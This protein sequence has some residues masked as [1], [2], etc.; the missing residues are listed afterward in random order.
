MRMNDDKRATRWW[1]AMVLLLA[2]GAAEAVP[3]SYSFTLG[4]AGSGGFTVRADADAPIIQYNA[5]R[6]ELSAFNWDIPGV[7][8]FDLADLGV[9]SLSSWNPA[10]GLVASGG[11]LSLL[12][13]LKAGASSDTGVG[14]LT[15]TLFSVVSWPPSGQ[16]SN[17]L[18]L[19]MINAQGSPCTSPG[20]LCAPLVP[21][22][23][24]AE[25]APTARLL[26]VADVPEP[27]SLVLA[28]AALAG[29]PLW[30]GRRRA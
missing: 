7:G 1:L 28:L 21:V 27:S 29:V 24:V 16:Q 12:F 10:S 25:S 19:V 15:C 11:S 5:S 14:C 22:L 8:S 30:R 9:F 2:V 3:L 17:A 20:G 13:S 4:A 23:S 6:H 26:R 18:G